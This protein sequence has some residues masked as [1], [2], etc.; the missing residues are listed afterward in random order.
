[1]F[2]QKELRRSYKAT[3]VTVYQS[4]MHIP[5]DVKPTLY[6]VLWSVAPVDTDTVNLTVSSIVLGMTSNWEIVAGSSNEFDS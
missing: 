4:Q 1:M 2:R 6:H 3:H 5:A